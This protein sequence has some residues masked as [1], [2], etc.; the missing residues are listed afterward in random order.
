MY[1]TKALALF[2]M[3]S[4][5]SACV[6]FSATITD[7]EFATLRLEDNGKQ[8]CKA[9]TY[10]GPNGWTLKCDK[11]YSARLRFKDDVVEYKA[12]HG[13]WTFKTKCERTGFGGAGRGVTICQASVFGC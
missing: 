13:Q 11:G 1:I 3:A 9:S 2:S 6:N 5:A 10:G 12:P 8:V 7:F 4:A